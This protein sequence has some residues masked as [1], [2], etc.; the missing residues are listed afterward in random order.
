MHFCT[1]SLANTPQIKLLLKQVQLHSSKLIFLDIYCIYLVISQG[2]YP[3]KQPQ[4]SVSIILEGKI[5]TVALAKTDYLRYL[6]L[7]WR[8]KPLS[9][10]QINIVVKLIG[11]ITTR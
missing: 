11:Y 6:W 1:F 3:S 10:S 2:F 7:F 9:Y 5:L 4:K 8:Q